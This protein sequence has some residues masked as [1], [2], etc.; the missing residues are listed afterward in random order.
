MDEF[1]IET[2]SQNIFHSKTKEYF[3]EVVSSYQA[4]NYRSAVVMLWSVVVCDL[5]FKLQNLV[6]M[7]GDETA[8]GILKEVSELQE[9]DEKSSTWEHRLIALVR[10]RTNFLDASEYENLDHLQLQRH[11]SA[12]PVVKDNKELYRPNRDTVRSLIRNTLD[13]V[14]VKPPIY[15]KKIFDEFI[16]D[17]SNSASLFIDDKILKTYLESKYFSKLSLEVEHSIFRFLWKL[18]FKNL[19]QELLKYPSRE[20]WHKLF[21]RAQGYSS[22]KSSTGIVHSGTAGSASAISPRRYIVGLSG[23]LARYTR[24]TS[25]LNK[26]T[27][28]TTKVPAAK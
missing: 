9:K 8:R 6:D 4:G 7:Y 11:L 15:T 20:D 1:S 23:S 3:E 19:D 22:N 25:S 14:L 10:Q 13:G 5:L 17:L 21:L 26:S 16:T 28:Q 2:R 27:S 24:T 18:I 12:H